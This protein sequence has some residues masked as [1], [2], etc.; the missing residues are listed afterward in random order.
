[1][2]ADAPRMNGGI[3]FAVDGPQA[4]VVAKAAA[5]VTVEDHRLWPMGAAEL[6]QLR[7]ALIGFAD[8]LGLRDGAAI[9]VEGEMRTHVG[10]GSATAIRL[11]ALEALALANGQEVNRA[12]L[13]TASGRGGTS[14]IGVN[15][16][17]DGGLICDIGRKSSGRF[18]PSSQAGTASSALALPS[19]R[20]PE[21]P[22]LLVLPKSLR[23]K[24]QAD[25]IN[26]FARTTPVPVAASYEASY[27]ALFELYA[28][29]AEVDF[30]AFCRG[31]ERMQLSAWKRAERAE[32]GEA[33]ATIGKGLLGAGARCVGMSS[34]GPLLFC[35]ADAGDV[36]HLS[37]VAHR[38]N[39]DVREVRPSNRGRVLKISNA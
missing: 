8:R 39:C 21:W 25:E 28:A 4:S 2:H 24:T 11:A 17:F 6:D 7:L 13:V 22:I 5:R 18:A 29:A 34:L 32:F 33:L 23:P 14:G 3:G 37:Q 10:M 16:Y 38:L 9:R 31:V 19:V 27:V 15:S 12:V 30:S 35:L 36:A 20:M 26:F 1:M